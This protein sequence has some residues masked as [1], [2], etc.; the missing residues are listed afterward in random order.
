MHSALNHVSATDY[1][2]Y[3]VF[4]M[5]TDDEIGMYKYALQFINDPDPETRGYAC[6]G[7]KS[8]ERLARKRRGGGIVA[9]DA[10]F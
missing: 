10:I 8:L 2:M 6:Y 4:D 5:L 7:I 9:T 3:K 1:T